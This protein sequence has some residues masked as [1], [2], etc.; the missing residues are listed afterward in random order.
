[1]Y[2]IIFI[3]AFVL[4]S[5]MYWSHKDLFVTCLHVF[6]SC[7]WNSLGVDISIGALCEP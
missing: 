4:H 1:M 3:G 2:L 7:G 5:C 6:L